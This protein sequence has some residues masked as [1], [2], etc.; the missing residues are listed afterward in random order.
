MTNEHLLPDETCPIHHPFQ[1][2]YPAKKQ[3][4]QETICKECGGTKYNGK[5]PD[6]ELTK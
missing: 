3:E 1:P 6:K 5:F 4:P 2:H